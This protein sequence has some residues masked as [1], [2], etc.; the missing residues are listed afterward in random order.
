MEHPCQTLPNRLSVCADVPNL[1]TP[2]QVTSM[3]DIM[4]TLESIE[5]KKLS[6]SADSVVMYD[7]EGNP[8][9]AL[10]SAEQRAKDLFEALD[11]DKD[12]VI[13]M[14]DFVSGYAYTYL[15]IMLLH[16]ALTLCP[17]YYLQRHP[18]SMD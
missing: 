6:E 10:P 8:E 4:E 3:V 15:Q 9:D 2:I 18:R 11:R 1:F 17:H 13:T 7:M 16:R 12:G 14:E 5:N